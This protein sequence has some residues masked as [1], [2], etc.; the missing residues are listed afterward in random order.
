MQETQLL[1]IPEVAAELGVDQSTIN[2]RITA[3]KLSPSAYVS[4]RAVFTADDVERLRRGEQQ[5]P[6]EEAPR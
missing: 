6:R 5:L 4:K 1:G 2:R 3:G